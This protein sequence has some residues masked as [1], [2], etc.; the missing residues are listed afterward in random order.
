METV[1]FIG[2]GRMGRPMA[3]NLCRKGFRLVVNDINPAAVQELEALQAR[4]VASV[5]EV[6]SQSDI[7]VTMLPNSAVVR[8]V[9]GA[10]NGVM[11]NLK[12][13]AIILDMSTVSPETSDELAAATKARGIGFVDAPVGGSRAMP[14]AASACSWPAAPW[15]TSRGSSPCSTGWAPQS[16]TAARPGPA[17]AR[18]LSTTTLPLRPAN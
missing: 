14:T 9:V 13:G 10:R 11:A 1:G 8:D 12:P 3:S 4:G 15:R 18:S 17:H 6:A 16:S 2:L 5:A 7:V